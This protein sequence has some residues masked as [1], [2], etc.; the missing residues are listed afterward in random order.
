MK[1]TV[2]NKPTDAAR[3]MQTKLLDGKIEDR[4]ISGLFFIFLSPIL[5]SK[6]TS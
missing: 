2:E 6:K 4:N 3:N 1:P 5:L